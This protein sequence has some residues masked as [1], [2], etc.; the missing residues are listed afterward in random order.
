MGM[1]RKGLASNTIIVDAVVTELGRKL[2]SEQRGGFDIVSWAPIDEEI[3]YRLC[4]MT[5]ATRDEQVKFLKGVPIFQAN[6]RQTQNPSTLLTF[7]QR[8]DTL[9]TLSLSGENQIIQL[10]ELDQASTP[11]SVNIRQNY[12][13]LGE[14]VPL[15]SAL[16]D[17][18][19]RVNVRNDF[20]AFVNGAGR[21]LRP[22]GVYPDKTAEYL[23]PASSI[24]R[25]YN[26]TQV[27]LNMVVKGLT[28]TTFDTFGS[29]SPGSRSIIFYVRV[30][31]LTTGA[32]TIITCKI[33]EQKQ[34]TT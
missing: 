6:T 3:D 7:E 5:L 33:T 31:G 16:A 13:V 27:T 30:A 32:S 4:D 24:D 11:R 25:T 18:V 28:S 1:N 9:P 12:V 22:T 10:K 17:S 34:R 29:G 21:R 20:I 19:Y 23:I 14:T 26:T 8:T 15:D 2:L